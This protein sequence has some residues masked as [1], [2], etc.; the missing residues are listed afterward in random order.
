MSFGIPV[1]T[2]PVGGLRD[3]FQDGV[4][5][6]FVQPGNTQQIVEKLD[7][8]LSNKETIHKIGKCNHDYAIK[9]LTS[10]KMAKRLNEHFNDMINV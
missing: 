9:N 2:T 8:L 6:Y 3:F 7:L 5:G 10:V 1:I 4:M